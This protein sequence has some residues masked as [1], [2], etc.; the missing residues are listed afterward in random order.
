MTNRTARA[1]TGSGLLP[2]VRFEP[3]GPRVIAL[4]SVKEVNLTSFLNS[5]GGLP[6]PTCMSAFPGRQDI[7][8]SIREIRMPSSTGH[9]PKRRGRPLM[10]YRVSPLD[11]TEA[12]K[13]HK[14]IRPDMGSTKR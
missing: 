9:T 6:A 8:T 3:H 12:D 2:T 4:I 10:T 1:A 11:G 14:C 13:E 7:H 5:R